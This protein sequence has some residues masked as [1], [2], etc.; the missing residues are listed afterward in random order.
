MSIRFKNDESLIQEASRCASFKDG[1]SAP[2]SLVSLYVSYTI[3]RLYSS[4]P[5][6]NAEEYALEATSQEL[7]SGDPLHMVVVGASA[8]NEE[9]R[10]SCCGYILPTKTQLFVWFPHQVSGAFISFVAFFWGGGIY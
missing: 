9:V 3:E 6:C 10:T 7:Y 5:V 2:L 1:L 8:V 4:A